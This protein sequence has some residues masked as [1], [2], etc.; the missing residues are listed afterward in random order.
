M[1]EAIVAQWNAQVAP[2]DTVWIVG[3]ICMGQRAQTLQ[4]V[5]RLRGHKHLVPGN[6][7]HC[8]PPLCRSDEKLARMTTMYAEVGL[9]IHPVHERTSFRGIPVDICHFPFEGDSHDEDRYTE[10]RPEDRGQWLIHG[11]V[12]DAWRQRGRQINVGMDAWGGRLVSMTTIDTLMAAGPQ[13][14]D[15]FEWDG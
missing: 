5:R 10:H 2:T 9:H 13:D 1:T 7:D 6:H 15:R 11:H 4:F 8:W 3:D 14:L 12:H